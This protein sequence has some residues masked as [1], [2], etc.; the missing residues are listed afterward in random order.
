VVRMDPV[1]KTLHGKLRGNVVDGVYA[2][3]GV[4]YAAPPFGA[5]R[6]RPPRPVEPWS[7]VRDATSFGP[8]PPQVSPPETVGPAV[9]RTVT[10]EDCLNLNLWTPDPGAAGLPVMVW[11]ARAVPLTRDELKAVAVG[12]L[13][14]LKKC[15]GIVRGF[16]G[17]PKPAY[18]HA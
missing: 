13:E 14:R 4:P 8:Q 15:P 2:F 18:I 7:G 10:G 9:E 11:I 6:L 3:L 12:A 17:D 16:F 1:V 5:N